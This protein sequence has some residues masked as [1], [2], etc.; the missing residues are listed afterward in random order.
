MIQ[1]G[2]EC[3]GF[4]LL[5]TLKPQIHKTPN[6]KLTFVLEYLSKFPKKVGHLA[7]KISK[8]VLTFTVAYFKS[9]EIRNFMLCFHRYFNQ[10]NDLGYD[11][12]KLNYPTI[13]TSADHL[14]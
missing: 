2:F 13:H 14:K 11:Q 1:C 8:M 12:H 5:V 4:L 6:V 3:H 10:L 9:G 7:S